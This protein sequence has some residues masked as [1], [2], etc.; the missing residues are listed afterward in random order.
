MGRRAMVTGASEGIGH[1]TA[2][3]LAQD[4]WDLTLVA[5]R[6][7]RLDALVAELGGAA[8]KVLV[9]DLSLRDDVARV[10][11]SL[12]EE[13][14]EFLFNNAGVGAYGAFHTQPLDRQLAMMELNMQSLVVL[15]HTWLATAQ[16]GDALINTSS[17]LGFMPMPGSAAY[18]ATKAFVT[19][20]SETLW[21]ENK[22]RGV[23][24]AALCPGL[25]TT[26]FHTASGGDAKTPPPKALS[27]SPE[28]VAEEL[29]DMLRNRSDPSVISGGKN[30]AMVFSSRLMSRKARVKMMGGLT[31]GP[32]PN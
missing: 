20:L 17:T 11:S 25:T 18:S 1:A 22:D 2:R 21:F 26:G 7:G 9:A 30:S 29:M 6:K 19:S 15:C 3:A 4:G 28:Q 14:C 5:R 27:Q 24:V 23:Y 13:R 10:A 8:H 12:K 32:S 16:K 31:A